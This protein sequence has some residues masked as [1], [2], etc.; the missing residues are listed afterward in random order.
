MNAKTFYATMVDSLKEPSL[1][2]HST[3]AVRDMARLTT[4]GSG[5]VS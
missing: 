1:L 3:C 2:C 5:I 4:G